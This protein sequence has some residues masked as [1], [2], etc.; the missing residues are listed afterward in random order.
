MALFPEDAATILQKLTLQQGRLEPEQVNELKVLMRLSTEDF[1]KAV[2]PLAA[3]MSTCPISGFSV[4]A[5][6]EG[7][8][9]AEGSCEEEQ[10]PIYF[11][12]NLEIA[13]QPLK[14]AI[15]A[16]QASISNAWHQ[17]ETRLRRL[18][19]N[20]APCGHCRQFMNELNEIDQME[21]LVSQLDNERKKHYRMADLLPDAFGPGDLKQGGRLL[22]PSN[23]LLNSPDS[24]D[25]LINAATQAAQNS[26]APYSDCYS[27][28]ALLMNNGDIISGMYAENVAFNPSLTAIEAALVNLRLNS[29]AKPEA[30]IVD[31]V[32]V[33]KQAPIS[34]KAMAVSIISHMGAELRH[35]IV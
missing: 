34:H 5:V 21:I 30:T 6:V 25:T 23:Q 13:G 4:G 17:G 18:M 1:L 33:E 11:G 9:A 3:T 27:G 12:A 31:A 32:M 8:R 2:L 14:M 22:G 26:Y 7:F 20:E 16:E 28:I 15:H 29:L 10:G 24:S 35:F 19:V